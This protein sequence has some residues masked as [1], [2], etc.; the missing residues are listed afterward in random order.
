[1]NQ[2]INWWNLS[3]NEHVKNSI[4]EAFNNKKLSYGPVGK[5]LEKKIAELFN[6]KHC[7]LTT[8]GSTALLVALKS[9]SLKSDDEV[10]VPNRTFQATANAVYLAGA[11]VRLADVTAE[12]GLIDIKS[13]ESLITT[14]T[15]AIM[16]VHLN[17]RACDMENILA[18]AKKHNLFIIEDTAQAFMSRLKGRLLGT[19]G[20]VNCFSLG[21]TKFITSGQGGFLITNSDQIYENAMKYIFHAATGDDLK[22]FNSFGFNFR[23]SDLLSSL[24]LAD[25][26]NLESKRQKYLDNYKLYFEKLKDCKCVEVI[27]S[28]TT[29]GEVPIWI[30][31]LSPKRN[32]LYSHLKANQI[33]SVKFYPS[34]NRSPYLEQQNISFPNS[35]KF[36]KSGLILPCGP[37]ILQSQIETVID[38][39]KTFSG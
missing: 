5:S 31:V 6:V 14:K 19:F 9:I 26:D 25:F 4:N 12:R 15:K 8:S 36:E 17:G 13:V 7:L 32:E 35:E 28:S 21:V 27:R 29:D 23:Q 20:D 10:I 11:K 3:L 24:A 2:P 22:E 1:M 16:P 33:E 39:I 18:L 34:L 37:N 38:K 30:E